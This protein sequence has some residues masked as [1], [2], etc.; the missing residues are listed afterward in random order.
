MQQ[1]TS[2]KQIDTLRK[3]EISRC[4]TIPTFRIVL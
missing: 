1:A 4:F 3:I 2:N